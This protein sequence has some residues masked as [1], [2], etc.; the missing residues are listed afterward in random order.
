MLAVNIEG[1]TKSYDGKQNALDN[2]SLEVPAGEIF[3]FLGPNGSGKTTTVRILNAILSPTSGKARI[4]DKDITKDAMHIH[5]ISGVMTESAACYENLT[6]EENL[7]FFGKMHGVEEREAQKRAES[8][9]KT[10][11][12][13][14][15][16]SKKVGNYSTGMRKRIQ[17][18]IALMHNPRILF[19]DE[20]TSG[21]DPE[22]AKNVTDYIQRLAHE[23]EVTVL[24]CTH[25]LKYAQ[26]ICTMYAFINNG[27]ILG[28]GSFDQLAAAKGA[29]LNLRI[30]GEG[31][32]SKYGFKAIDSTNFTKAITKDENVSD[33]LFDI[34][35]DGGKIYEAVHEKWDLEQLYFSYVKGE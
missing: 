18:A 28:C 7:M 35:K 19:L 13:S 24:L 29:K 6:G 9:L 26:D 32:P 21:L 12:L 34:L 10:L 20:P 5:R 33:L 8:L 23:K 25:Q 30:R 16:R 22:T 11:E 27:S 4:F 31:I 3:G 17:L 1:I 15:A 2:I 14:D